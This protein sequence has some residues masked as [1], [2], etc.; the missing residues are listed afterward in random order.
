MIFNKCYSWIEWKQILTYQHY[1]YTQQ[2]FEFVW[3]FKNFIFNKKAT[4]ICASMIMQ[5]VQNCVCGERG[6]WIE[7]RRLELD[8]TK[9]AYT[10]EKLLYAIHVIFLGIFYSGQ[11]QFLQLSICFFPWIFIMAKICSFVK[12]VDWSDSNVIYDSSSIPG[13]MRNCLYTALHSF[14]PPNLRSKS[15]FLYASTDGLADIYMCFILFFYR[16]LWLAMAESILNIQMS[17][18]L[19]PCGQMEMLIWAMV[20]FISA[21]VFFIVAFSLWCAEMM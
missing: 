17:N 14:Y 8:K 6:K 13:L 20:S 18:K 10:V 2:Y 9:F 21:N 15:C 4:L 5:N 7:E 19:E 16:N 3:I 11:Q 12:T 1:L